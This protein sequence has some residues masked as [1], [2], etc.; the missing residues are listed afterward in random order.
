MAYDEQIL[1]ILSEAG[2][3]GV[4]VRKLA[5]NVYNMCASFF[6][7]PDFESVYRHVQQF[8]SKNSQ[9][10]SSLVEH[11]SERGCYRL[12]TSRSP[13]ARQLMLEFGAEEEQA[14]PLNAAAE[15]REE[16]QPLSLFDT[17]WKPKPHD[18]NQSLSLFD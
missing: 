8:L 15:P 13:Q 7:T 1:R 3:H 14:L 6:E 11:T 5:L 17:E 18:P 10:A 4:S 9:T 2:P 12:N 16:Q